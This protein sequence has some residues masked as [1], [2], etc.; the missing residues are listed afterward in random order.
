MEKPPD[1]NNSNMSAIKL[2][3]GGTPLPELNEE[4]DS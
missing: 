4:E 1:N 3:M 2:L